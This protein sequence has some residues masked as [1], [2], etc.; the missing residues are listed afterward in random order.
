VA[1]HTR[2]LVQPTHISRR[3][4]TASGFRHDRL[5][6]EARRFMFTHYA[7]SGLQITEIARHCGVSRR[8]L[9]T[10]FAMAMRR[11]LLH[12][13]TEVRMERA[14]ALL[15]DSLETVTDIARACGFSDPNYFTKAFRQRHS[16]SP[17]KYR[18]RARRGTP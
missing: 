4:S 9:E 13:L 16:L 11:T 17:L 5:V 1:P 18:E 12:E 15:R 6:A 2:I 14:R 10:R 3:Q 7:S 8:L